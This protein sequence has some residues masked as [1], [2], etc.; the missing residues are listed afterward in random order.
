MTARSLIWKVAAYVAGFLEN[1]NFLPAL[2]A[3]ADR[4]EMLLFLRL[5]L[6]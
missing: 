5:N 3:R 2:K 1:D 6:T 4:P